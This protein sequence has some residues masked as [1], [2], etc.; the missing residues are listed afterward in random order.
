MPDFFCTGQD[1]AGYLADERC[2]SGV[3]NTVF[4]CTKKLRHSIRGGGL[5]CTKSLTKSQNW[6]FLGVPTVGSVKDIKLKDV[7]LH[8]ATN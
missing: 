4:A 1:S 7:K 5:N 2:Q 8:S 3:A 6:R